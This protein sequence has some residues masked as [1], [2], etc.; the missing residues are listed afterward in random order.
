MTE[1]TET[2]KPVHTE[3]ALNSAPFDG[4]AT[5]KSGH[6]A[7]EYVRSICLRLLAVSTLPHEGDTVWLVQLSSCSSVFWDLEMR[8]T[9]D[10]LQ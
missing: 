10:T 1:A 4:P 2:A 8:K 5:I 9:G 7:H 3:H 6:A